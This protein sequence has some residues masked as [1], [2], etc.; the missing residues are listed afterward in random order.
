MATFVE[1]QKLRFNRFYFISISGS[2]IITIC[3]ICILGSIITLGFLWW[4]AIGFTSS[5]LLFIMFYSMCTAITK[6]C[7]T[8]VNCFFSRILHV[9]GDPDVENIEQGNGV[10]SNRFALIEIPIMRRKWPKYIF[11]HRARIAADATQHIVDVAQYIKGK[12]FTSDVIYVLVG[13]ILLSAL[14]SGALA[15]VHSMM[16][17]PKLDIIISSTTREAPL[18]S[19][20]LIR[21]NV[22]EEI[23][24]MI[25]SRSFNLSDVVLDNSNNLVFMEVQAL[26][27]WSGD[28]LYVQKYR[29]WYTDDPVERSLLQQRTI[30]CYVYTDDVGVSRVLD[31]VI[32]GK[33][34]LK[35][36]EPK[37]KLERSLELEQE[38]LEFELLE[39][40]EIED[41]LSEL[42]LELSN[43]KVYL[44]DVDFSD[45]Q[46]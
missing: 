43:A 26:I 16:A 30:P 24:D 14:L 8:C 3:I 46:P 27:T 40:H 4:F 35:L 36:F 28:G 44:A 39:E 7:G 1:L 25:K 32:S 41:E 29:F 20:I 23:P 10:F 5:A 33:L 2:S 45:L 12:V 13:A 34:K 22:I 31:K 21:T 38:L 6:H 42:K 17:T 11:K 9:S 18:T 37:L 19:D 15:L